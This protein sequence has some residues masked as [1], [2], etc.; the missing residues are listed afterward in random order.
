MGKACAVGVSIKVWGL[1]GIVSGVSAGITS[2]CFRHAS[3][4]WAKNLLAFGPFPYFLMNF[5]MISSGSGSASSDFASAGFSCPLLV[6]GCTS[7]G[8]GCGGT[9][10]RVGFSSGGGDGGFSAAGVELAAS[11]AFFLVFS[12]GGFFPRVVRD[13]RFL[14]IFVYG[15]VLRRWL[16]VVVNG[17][18]FDGSR[19]CRERKKSLGI[20][21]YE[22]IILGE[23][24]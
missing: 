2:S 4:I 14:C 8:M 23:G 15:G 12:F 20:R 3:D 19:I 13:A 24:S 5:C 7:V 9:S 22:K 1:G 21:S 18:G 17:G 16:M 6:S 10:G 11:V